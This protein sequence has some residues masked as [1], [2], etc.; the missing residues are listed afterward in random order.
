M[1][2]ESMQEVE[3]AKYCPTCKHNNLVEYQEPCN[4]CLENPY[5]VDS[6]RPLHWE[7]K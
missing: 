6:N 7:K 3:F 5:L 4:E 1:N 2:D